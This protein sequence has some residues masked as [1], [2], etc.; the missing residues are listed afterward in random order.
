MAKN[1]ILEFISFEHHNELVSLA[2]LKE[3]LGFLQELDEIYQ[4]TKDAL[5]IDRNNDVQFMVAMMLLQAHSEFYIGISQFLKSHLSKAFISLRIA[6]DASFNAYYFTKKPEHTR[7]FLD[8]KSPL[9]KKIFWRIKD[10]ISKNPKEYPLAQSLIKIHETASLFAG[11]ASLQSIIYKYQHIIDTEQKK[12][13]VK[14]NYFDTLDFNNFM[15][16]YFALLKG[17]LMVFHL[18]YSCFFKKE[19]RIEYPEREK[20]IADFEAKLN[21]KGKQYPLTKNKKKASEGED[22]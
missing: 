16:Y 5:P 21:L 12:E 15:A 18:F 22:G 2:N 14:L 17:Y 6:I 11:H 10:H 13:E 8:E 19:F 3:E 7:E 4:D 1:N 9:Q 20:R